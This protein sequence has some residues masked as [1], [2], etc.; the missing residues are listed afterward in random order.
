M[1]FIRVIIKKAFL[2]HQNHNFFN[3][4]A[5]IFLDNHGFLCYYS[6][7]EPLRYGFLSVLKYVGTTLD[8]ETG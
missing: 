3:F 8:G 5:L 4:Y 7:V 2:L 1:S 6:I